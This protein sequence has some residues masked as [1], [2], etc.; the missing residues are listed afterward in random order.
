MSIDVSLFHLINGPAGKFWLLDW[1]GT[2]LAS[3]FAYILGVVFL[4]LLIKEKNWKKR[5]YFFS[6][7]ALST[8]LSRG[9]ITETIRFI[10]AR[11]RPFAALSF[12]PL[13]SQETGGSFPSG[14]ATFFFA[15]AMTVFYMVKDSPEIFHKNWTWWFLGGT[16]LMTI[17]RIYAGVHWPSDILGGA[18]IGILCAASVRRFLPFPANGKVP[19]NENS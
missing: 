13:L 19:K 11:P 14:H 3:P 12:T 7:A 4:Y 10:Y 15:L 1:V 2:F 17:A 9:I 16:I 18:L 6:L 8:I 5:I